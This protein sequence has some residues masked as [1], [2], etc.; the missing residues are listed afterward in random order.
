M[1]TA[2]LHLLRGLQQLVFGVL[3]RRAFCR[4]SIGLHC[5]A[6]TRYHVSN[7]RQRE[8][9]R[10]LARRLQSE[11][12]E[13]ALAHGRRISVTGSFT[14]AIHLHLQDASTDSHNLTVKSLPLVVPWLQKTCSRSVRLLLL[15]P[16]PPSTNK[17]PELIEKCAKFNSEILV[18][19]NGG[20]GTF[21][22]AQTRS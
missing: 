10:R 3:A 7:H 2:I 18:I 1:A 8:L 21:W 22:S 5:R 19:M 4:W 14:T 20:K 9:S 16:V 13:F 15:S 6:R 12:T 17:L 11:L